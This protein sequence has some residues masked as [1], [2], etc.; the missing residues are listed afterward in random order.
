MP[1]LRRSPPSSKSNQESTIENP[2][3]ANMDI[4]ELRRMVI[5]QQTI[6]RLQQ[7]QQQQQQQN[8]QISNQGIGLLTEGNFLHF[9]IRDALD[10]VPTYDGENIPFIYFVEGCEEAMSMIAPTQ[11]NI[12]VRA[13]R[14]KLKG[15]AHRSILGKIF[16]NMRELIEF[17][18]TKYGPRET[19]YEAQGRLAYLCQKKDEKV[20]TYANR[21]RELGKRILD[22]QKR[23]TGEI[24]EE[25]QNSIEAHLK[26][27]FLRG[28]NK[29]II[30]SKEG[31]FEQLESR[32]ID[33]EKELETINM[34]RR[35]VLAENTT[36][37]RA[38]RRI[39][40]VEIICQYCHKKG[41]TADRCRKILKQQ[42]NVERINSNNPIQ[43]QK[44]VEHVNQN[45]LAPIQFPV[46]QN[47]PQNTTNKFFP[48]NF[49]RQAYNKSFQ[50][51]QILVLDKKCSVIINP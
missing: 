15:D 18:R 23:E 4:T 47:F 51:N 42:G 35:V 2:N 24:S 12:L 1:K 5:E 13:I 10:A 16:T 9:S 26:T 36:E 43:Y 22:A 50:N 20:A 49:S 32:A 27:S 31:T 17:L 19:V 29:E 33:A 37:R 28:L 38:T 11:E 21:V 48:Q 8:G 3:Q 6:G 39:E 14:N 44:N 45:Y 34:I 7:Q 41:H 46:R 40:A 25:F 30:I